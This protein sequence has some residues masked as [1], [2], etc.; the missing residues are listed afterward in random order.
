MHIDHKIRLVLAAFFVLGFNPNIF[1][2]GSGGLRDE[3][4]DAGAFGKGSAFVGQADTPAAVYYNPAGMNQIKS[5]TITA[6]DIFIAPMAE[7]QNYPNG[8]DVKADRKIFNIPDFYA[9]TPVG[10]KL[11]L[12]FGSG[13]YWGLG[14]NWGNSSTL[15]YASTS[16]TIINMD[17]SLAASYQITDQWSFA[18]SAD[19]DYSKVDENQKLNAFG[20]DYGLEI[21]EKDDAWGYRLATMFRINDQNQIGLMYRSRVN[22]RYS[23]NISIDNGF[24]GLPSDYNTKVTEKITLPQSFIMGYSFKPTHRWTLNFDLEWMDWASF[25][26][27]NLT[28][29]NETNP[30]NL[31]ILS[32]FTPVPHD[33]KS[34]WSESV[35]AEYAA[36]EKLRLRGGY[37][38]HV[39]VGPDNTF[40]P[41]LPDMDS[42]GMTIGF[43]YSFNQHLSLDVAYGLAIYEPR[44]VENNPNPT[45]D[46]RYSE[47]TNFGAASLTYKF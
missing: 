4:P 24:F 8:N 36:T 22:H 37:F 42:H 20:N 30:T 18:A 19:N 16:A 11:S 13:S 10:K 35:G 33:W 5:P 41:A 12:G 44:K 40:N 45:V 29:P 17:T 7:F 1:A 43:G 34:S 31:A 47:I 21:K 46:G 27:E 23:G 38:H 2:A 26:K 32:N 25:K 6:G 28:F 15:K 14:T 39:S 9:V 3:T